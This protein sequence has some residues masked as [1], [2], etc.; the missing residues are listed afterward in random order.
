MKAFALCGAG[1]YLAAAYSA[2]AADA[3]AGKLL[4]QQRCAACHIVAPD[5]RNE[6][7]DAPPFVVIGRKFGFDY[8]SIVIALIG[9]HRKMN[10]SLRRRDAE[11]IAAYI[12]TLAQ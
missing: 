11:D 4:A 12:G 7:A 6:V 1:L 5:G 3:E 9:P 8:D 10:F 2:H